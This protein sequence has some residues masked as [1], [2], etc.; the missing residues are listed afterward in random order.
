MTAARAGLVGREVVDFDVI[1]MGDL[2]QGGSGVAFLSPGLF[3]AFATEAFGLG[4]IGEVSLVG[5]G[6]LT[7][8]T[9]VS[10]KFGDA[11]FEF[12]E[13]FDPFP[14]AQHEIGNGLGVSLG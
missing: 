10:L 5:G 7:A 1:G 2:L 9:A 13:C 4:W 12:F 3:A 6:W 8:G 11:G 14:Q